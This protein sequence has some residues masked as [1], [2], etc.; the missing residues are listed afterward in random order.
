[1]IAIQ[2]IIQIIE[3][4][5]PPAYQESY[6]N[7]GLIVGNKNAEATGVLVC[8]D[9]TEAVVEEAIEK[10]VNLIVAHHPI[11]FSG[12]KS[13]TGKNYIERTIIKAIKHDIAIYAAHTNI[14]S[15]KGGVNSVI[16]QKLKLE[17]I[18]ILAPKK[19]SLLKLAA[20]VPEGYTEQ[21]KAALFEAGCGH[22]GNYSN[23]SF[24]T[25]GT[26]SFLAGETTKPFVGTKGIAHREKEVRIET[27]FPK[28]L[29]YKVINALKK[30][31]PY[32]E[33]AFDLYPLANQ[34]SQV[35]LGMV[36]N[37]P[38]KIPT[39]TF[40]EQ[41]KSTFQTKLIRHTSICSS[42]ISRVA[43]CG[44]SGSFLLKGAIAAKADVYVTGD[45]KYHE[46]FDA[47]N[48]ILIADIGHYESEQ[49]T[50]ELFY[51]LLTEKL[52]SFAV[53]FTS[54]NTNPVNYF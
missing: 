46:F 19:D 50:M 18:E 21:V 11:I 28:H 2:D 3:D 14:D 54:T 49:Y 40:L 45:F 24:E 16:C 42:T 4:F 20:F 7:A 22:I 5:A 26:G 9:S 53:Y 48:K 30:A 17:N 38:E 39:E 47:E 25:T 34:N 43:V 36:G 32:E 1:M 8:L 13:F 52:I 23:C 41:L 44:G 6:D 51:N 15:V 37:L 33:V 31:H 29:E 10:G 27:I 35:G 12:L